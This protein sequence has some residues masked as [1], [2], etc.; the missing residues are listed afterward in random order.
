MSQYF[1]VFQLIFIKSV[2][3]DLFPMNKS[4]LGEDGEVFPQNSSH[5]DEGGFGV[6]AAAAVRVLGDRGRG[7]VSQSRSKNCSFSTGKRTIKKS[8]LLVWA[9]FRFGAPLRGAGKRPLTWQAAPPPF[10]SSGLK[11]GLVLLKRTGGYKP[12]S[13]SSPSSLLHPGAFKKHN[14]PGRCRPGHIG[15]G[16]CPLCLC[17][18]H[19]SNPPPPPHPKSIGL[20]HLRGSD[21]RSSPQWTA[22]QLLALFCSSTFAPTYQTPAREG[23]EA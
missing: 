22:F 5:T 2:P 4:L 20:V 9:V 16:S 12:A 11:E 1:T 13:L 8:P 10:G 23:R 3:F 19:I 14:Y 15:N 6:G 18:W 7:T 17:H 21:S